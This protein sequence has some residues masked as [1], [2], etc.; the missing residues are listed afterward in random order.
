MS[1]LRSMEEGHGLRRDARQERRFLEE[2][3]VPARS[4]N[5]LALNRA[6]RLDRGRELSLRGT[7]LCPPE[8][9]S[10][11]LHAVVESGDRVVIE[12]DNQ[13]QAD[14][15]ASGLASLDPARVHDLHII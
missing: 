11:L 1:L 7:K 3:H 10:D 6:G 8:R 13:K 15:L 14:L 9:L 2:G 12:G 5:T 4:W